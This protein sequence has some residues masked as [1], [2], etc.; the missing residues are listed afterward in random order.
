MR[1]RS[2]QPSRTA[3]GQSGSWMDVSE[4]PEDSADTF[5]GKWNLSDC[6]LLQM[7]L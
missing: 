1:I 5:S 3:A 7:K 4:A 6:R 2:C